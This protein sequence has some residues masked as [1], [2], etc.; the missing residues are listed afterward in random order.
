MLEIRELTKIY[1]PKRGVPVTALD[2]VSLRLPSHGMVFLLG[3]SGS[4]KSTLLNLLG[5]L[6]RADSGE[7]LIRGASAENFR[8]EH[9]DSY[10]NTYVGFIFQEY[11]ILDEFTV[12]A[13]IALAIE[14][15]GRRATD[16]QIAQIL[17]EVD[18]DGYGARRPNELSGG[19]KQRVAIARALVK[20]PR[21][22]M[23]DEP[24][25]ALDSATGRQILD[26]L[27]RLSA[28]R[29]VIVVSHDREF[30]ERYADRI[31]EL[32]DGRVV[33]DVT[34]TEQ[35][36]PPEDTAQPLTFSGS[37]VTLAPG[38]HLTEEDRAQINAYIDALAKDRPQAVTLAAAPAARRHAVP[39]DPAA[40]QGEGG[41][42]SLIRSRLPLR[43][44]FKIGGSSLGHKR[45]RLAVTI[46]LSCIAFGLFGLADTFAGYDHI[47]ACTDS[48][49]DTGTDYVAVDKE[50][51]VT[52]G[53]SADNGPM[54]VSGLRLLPKDLSAFTEQ[55]GVPVVG[56]Y[57]PRDTRL[58][59][60]ESLCPADESAATRLRSVFPTALNGLAQIDEQTLERLG[61]PLVAGRLPDG[62]KDEIVLPSFVCQSFIR[63]GYTDGRTDEKGAPIA[64][65][66]ASAADMVGK[67]IRIDEK[68]F[69]VTGVIDTQPDLERYMVLTEPQTD[70][71][72]TVEIMARF[73]LSQE[74]SYALRYSLHATGF[75]GGGYVD[76]L[77]AAEPPTR[78]INQNEYNS[79]YLYTEQP[80]D[81]ANDPIGIAPDYIARLSD[82]DRKDIVWLDGAQT[83]LGEKDLIVSLDLIAY[84]LRQMQSGSGTTVTYDEDTVDEP[85]YD[86]ENADLPAEGDTEALR[87]LVRRLLAQPGNASLIEDS[88]RTT[89]DDRIDGYRIV[90]VIDYRT[91]PTLSDTVVVGSTL[92]S[93]LTTDED[94]SY[95]F[96]AG[97]MPDTADGVR[98]VV[99]T[100]YRGAD[101]VRYPLSNAVT[102]EL[103]ALNDLLGTLAKGFLWVGIAFALF[104]SLMLANF[105]AVSIAY[106]KQEIGILRAIGSRSNDVFRIF[107]AEAFII[108]MIN[109]VLSTVGVA[110]L[111]GWINALI[112]SELHIL[113]TV[114]GFGLRQTV[115]LLA[116]SLLVAA[117]ASFFPVR[118][119]A[120]KRPIDAIRGR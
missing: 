8:Q 120:A 44:A 67:T 118:R 2:H 55:T 24:T 51:T 65:K 77:I 64:I 82:V 111:T 47:R 106:K 115:L 31:I 9:F 97:R 103:D 119:I 28:D 83:A 94:G 48:L 49:L 54:T 74:W 88:R 101:G 63:M 80:D 39:T 113:V 45:L 76:R 72:T 4:G 52:D 22:I 38:Y 116:V 104:A 58:W 32:A 33:A 53:Q 42:F 46:V 27:K 11:N 40:V 7:I 13:N 105:I 19:Q 91:S 36:A 70:D 37:T 114:L 34:Y 98:T 1:R 92:Y 79:L 62:T 20:Q 102:F 26:T 16:E 87:Q 66:V 86:D 59:F 108:A 112:R 84:P 29:L 6:D 23:A 69:T 50:M 85:V 25:G 78:Q 35:S 95:T 117:L 21:I 10:R 56:V 100:C 81:A 43:C 73:A 41:G 99:R 30:A 61:W 109:F 60:S 93:L 17:H 14:L 18:L 89:L 75:V 71:M 5:G 15:Q 3:K 90:G 110:L 57:V 68:T 12:G 107:F 96:A